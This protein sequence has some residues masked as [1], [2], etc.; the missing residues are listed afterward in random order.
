MADRESILDWLRAKTY[1]VVNERHPAR[2]IVERLIYERKAEWLCCANRVR[3][4]KAT[5]S[6]PGKE[7]R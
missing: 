5:A 4:R 7:T 1:R 6:E 2:R 3:A